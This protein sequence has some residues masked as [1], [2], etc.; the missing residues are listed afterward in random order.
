M[1][2][3]TLLSHAVAAALVTATAVPLT[4]L[5]NEC[6][7]R[8][9]Y[10]TTSNNRI[11]VDL[12]IP[13]NQTIEIGRS[14]LDY[15]ANTGI[16][17]VMVFLENVP[18]T[19][20]RLSSGQNDPAAGFHLSA[21]AR[22]VSLQCLSSVTPP[23]LSAQ[24]WATAMRAAG[25]TA[26]T[27]ATGL[28]QLF[29]RTLSQT[30]QIL[31]T[32]G[33]T[34]Q[35]AA[36]AAKAVFDPAAAAMANA[37]RTVFNRSLVQAA[38]I[39]RNIGYTA[40]Q[41]AQGV[42]DAYDAT[43]TQVA[44]RLRALYNWSADQTVVLL[45][46]LGYTIDQVGAA[47]RDAY[48]QTEA[49]VIRALRD[50]GYTAGQVIGAA[51][52]LYN[53]SAQQIATW[54]REAG[55]TVG[56]LLNPLVQAFNLGLEA[57]LDAL[58]NAGYTIQETVSAVRA[59]FNATMDDI[60]RIT[61]LLRCG[62]PIISCQPSQRDAIILALA[63]ALSATQ[64]FAN[65]LARVARNHMQHTAEQAARVLQA[66]PGIT[67][68]MAE[69]ALLGAGWAVAQVQAAL[70]A[71]YGTGQTLVQTGISGGQ[72]L[73][74]QGGTMMQQGTEAMLAGAQAT[75]QAVASYTELVEGYVSYAPGQPVPLS[76]R[77]STTIVAKG[78]LAN[79]TTGMR[80]AARGWQVSKAEPGGALFGPAASPCNDAN[81]LCI[82]VAPGR[83]ARP[84]LSS[85]T[86]DYPGG[87]TQTVP[88]RIVQH[89][90]IRGVTNQP[91]NRSGVTLT[92]SS[93]DLNA[94]E[95][96]DLQIQG[97]NLAIGRE[98]TLDC[99]NCSAGTTVNAVSSSANTANVR[100]TVNNINRV[101]GTLR[102]VSPHSARHPETLSF[103]VEARTDCGEI[104]RRR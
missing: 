39:L 85:I 91:F 56:Q 69:A 74:E 7:V 83:G 94:R 27:I 22:L 81:T 14:R 75:A 25:A 12:T 76:Q 73:L 42:K 44:Q 37:L 34:A 35:Q 5:A 101:T 46:S 59:R 72:Q 10:N 97:E 95:S 15:V 40:E 29:G 55:Y 60:I 36:A 89:A 47:M 77:T 104:Q 98:L 71:A 70:D 41:M 30:M 90:N 87:F 84:G 38:Q 33:Y 102:F 20:I 24:N 18:S 11:E 66:I 45:R 6:N 92:R 96:F 17:D 67:R 13:V 93:C 62:G 28:N 88:V 48:Q 43:A 23:L 21:N 57:T 19:V 100:V 80:M 54:M 52:S 68:D 2:P 99:P 78:V 82:N 50:A 32:I 49:Q 8:Y 64:E 65:A 86:V 103:R 53:A 79:T 51:R 31:Q 58:L 9:Q 3:R 4:A 16:N 63:E 1:N 61:L 26:E